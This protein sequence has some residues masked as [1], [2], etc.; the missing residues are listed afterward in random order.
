[1]SPHPR[2]TCRLCGS[3]GFAETEYEAMGVCAKCVKKLAHAFV[4]KHHGE[5]DPTFSP[6]DE[7]KEWA[8]ARAARKKAGKQPIPSG[9]RR[10]VLERDKFRCQLCGDHRDLQVDHIHPEALGGTLD[11]NNL[12]CLCKPCNI[13]KGKRV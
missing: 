1:M 4:M 8:L 6:P 3:D 7:Y 12:Q 5:P 9:I 2:F 10:Q 13:K 11:L